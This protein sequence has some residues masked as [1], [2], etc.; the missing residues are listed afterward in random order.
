MDY[1][2]II[3]IEPGKRGGKPCVRGLRITVYD[4]LDYPAS[5]MS[6]DQIL[7]DFPDLTREDIRACLAF[8]GTT[9]VRE[10]GLSRAPDQDIWDFARGH[11]YA[12]VS[13]DSDFRQLSLL[14]GHPPKV[15]W[16]RIGNASTDQI[17]EL[18]KKRARDLETFLADRDASFLEL[19]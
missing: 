11:G 12:V 15:I 17:L 8:H 6:E 7:E 5:G 2:K 14:N 13:K 1:R 18:M 16:I 9:H 19:P 4:V 3:T 10:F